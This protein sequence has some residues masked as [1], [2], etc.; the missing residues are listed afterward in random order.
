MLFTH[1]PDPQESIRVTFECNG[2][3]I[4]LAIKE[5]YRQQ[6]ETRF[7]ALLKEHTLED[8]E[9]WDGVRRFG[10]DVWENWHRRDLFEVTPTADP[11]Q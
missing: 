4:T 2:R 5:Q 9:Y 3:R 7:A 6:I 1:S 11:D 10:L 8:R